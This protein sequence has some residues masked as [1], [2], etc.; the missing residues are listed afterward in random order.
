MFS[1]L[2]KFSLKRPFSVPHFFTRY[3]F[4]SIFSLFIPLILTVYLILAKVFNVPTMGDS[5]TDGVIYKLEKSTIFLRKNET[6]LIA[7]NNLFEKKK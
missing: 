6:K 7:Y 4:A 5:I 2:A 1:K 3:P